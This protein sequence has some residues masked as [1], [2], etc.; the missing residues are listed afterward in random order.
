MSRRSASPI[1]SLAASFDSHGLGARFDLTPGGRH[2]W[3]LDLNYVLRSDELN[4]YFGAIGYSVN[5]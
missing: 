5:F 3:Y 1:S 2:D 4:S